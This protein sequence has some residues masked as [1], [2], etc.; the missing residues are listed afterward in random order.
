M[1]IITENHFVV[2]I[3]II[4]LLGVLSLLLS[5][6]QNAIELPLE[7]TSQ[8]S[9]TQI[10]FLI[11]INPLILLS[12]SVLV[13]NLCFGKVGLEAP[14]LSSKFDLQK[15]QPLI[16][17]FLKVGVISGIVLGIILILISVVSEKVISSEL[18]NSP[19]SSSLNIIT[20]LMYGGI[21]EEIFMR[22]GLM[23]FLVWIIAKI[24]NSES[25]W[26]FLSAI[27]ISSLM[28][29]LGHLP[30]VYATV[31]VVSFGLVT[32]ILI[33]NSVAGLVYGYLYW[34]KGLECSMIS[35][36]TTH[37]TFVVANFLF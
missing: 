18:V 25:N 19:L 12:I 30:I 16:R 1:K 7:I 14:I 24:S 20:R 15:I 10:Q 22:F 17:D 33:G 27:L 21:T 37:I 23:T 26:V 4:G 2:K 13:G 31:E 36:M 28:F 5:N 8:Y 29:A 35:H 9:S 32:Y 3:F 6:F 34:K 11:L